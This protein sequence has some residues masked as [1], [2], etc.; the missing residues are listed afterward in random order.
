MKK[1]YTLVIGTFLLCAALTLAATQGLDYSGV[2]AEF[3]KSDDAL[4][5][6]VYSLNYIAEDTSEVVPKFVP[7]TLGKPTEGFS[8]EVNHPPTVS[9]K[10]LIPY[11][12]RLRG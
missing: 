4:A 2:R 1:F 8:M 7:D 10:H 11:S 6:Q 9:R 3:V 12:K 5:P